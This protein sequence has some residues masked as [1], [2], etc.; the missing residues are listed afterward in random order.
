[1]Y[2]PSERITRLK[3]YFY[4]G[5]GKRIQELRLGGTDVIRMD[6]GSPDLPPADFIIDRMVQC[7]RRS[8]V[9]GYTTFGGTPAY[10]EAVASYY[11]R[12]FGL[13][14]DP[15]QE[16]VGLIGSKEGIFALS[17][18]S[19]N[20]GDISLV[21]DP[22]YATY[23]MGA[24]LAGAEVFS[25][26]LTAEN[27]FLPDLD[28]IP[29]DVLRRARVLWLNYPNNPT[30]AVATMEF[31]ECA[32]DFARR[33]NLV[34]AHDA[35]YTDICYGDYLAPS[36]LQVPGARRVAIEFNSLS[37]TYNMAGWRLGMAVGNR[38]MI[39]AMLNYKSQSDSGHYEPIL[40]GGI[41]A[42]TGDQSWLEERNRIYQERIDFLA[43]GLRGLGLCPLKP[44]AALYVWTPTPQGMDDF[45]FCQRLLEETGVSATPGPVYGQAGR[46]YFRMSICT[47]MDQIQ[48]ALSR[49]SAWLG[50]G[51]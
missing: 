23:R 12:R 14:F 29:A 22:G 8:D 39:S 44:R 15:D 7:A 50:A 28:C 51:R 46:G 41:A 37:K 45:D 35:P 20:P 42:L 16:I 4:S 21:T 36:I 26:P 47:P 6:M 11:E 27:D 19:L 5:L 49:M 17:Q 32:V 43:E 3:P 2:T 30:G 18:I 1:M 24:Q 10:R 9:H 33:H 13:Q 48:E 40:Q 34:V 25:L 31:F 38:E